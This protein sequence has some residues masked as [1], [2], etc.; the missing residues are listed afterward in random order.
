MLTRAE[1]MVECLAASRQPEVVA[2]LAAVKKQ[3]PDA[4]AAHI[5][6]SLASHPHLGVKLA[7]A[8]D[9]HCTEATLRALAAHTDVRETVARNPRCPPALWKAWLE[10]TTNA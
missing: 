10:G 5:V 9:P 8:S 3:K 2:A 6:N 1:A 7:V 4:S